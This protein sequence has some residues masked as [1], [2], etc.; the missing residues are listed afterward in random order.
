MLRWSV[1]KTA[2]RHVA[3][4][5]HNRKVITLWTFKESSN[6][7]AM[8]ANREFSESFFGNHGREITFNNDIIQDKH[9]IT[10]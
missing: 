7:R 4:Q 1:S 3:L 2:K 8:N 9:G 6:N 10:L 5:W